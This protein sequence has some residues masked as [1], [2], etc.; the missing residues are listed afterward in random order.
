MFNSL[1][2]DQFNSSSSFQFTVAQEDSFNS[3]PP[4][5]QPT[6]SIVLHFRS[7]MRLLYLPTGL[8]LQYIYL[9][10]KLNLFG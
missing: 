7:L 10:V 9:L 2:C 1:P 8:D 4:S 3:P 6:H 5:L